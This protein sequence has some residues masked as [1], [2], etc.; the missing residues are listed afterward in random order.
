M[1]DPWAFFINSVHL[2]PPPV[3]AGSRRSG[4]KREGG[5]PS[6]AVKK[7]GESVE[8]RYLQS[9]RIAAFDRHRSQGS[10]SERE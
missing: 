7:L 6:E 9:F 10:A 3:S 4:E 8:Q 5:N 1:D 2:L